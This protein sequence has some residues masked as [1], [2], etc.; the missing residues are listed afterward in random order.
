MM[1][2]RHIARLRAFAGWACLA[3]AVAIAALTLPLA[4]ANATSDDEQASSSLEFNEKDGTLSIEWSGPI[5]PGMA[6]YLRGVLDKYAAASHRVVLFLNS[7]GGD[8]DEGD[9]VIH[10]LDG[11]KPTHRLITVVLDGSLCASMCIPVFLPGP[12]ARDI[13]GFSVLR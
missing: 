12:P 5:V 10:L 4:D 13:Q 11:I 7:A 1:G 3:A 6:D 8:V 2:R 9:R